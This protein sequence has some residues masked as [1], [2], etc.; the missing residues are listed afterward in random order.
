M[1]CASTTCKDCGHIE[2]NAFLDFCTKCGS[3]HVDAE[4]DVEYDFGGPF[5]DEELEVE[6][7]E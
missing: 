7:G 3:K 2:W 4:H 5:D 6:H 1:A